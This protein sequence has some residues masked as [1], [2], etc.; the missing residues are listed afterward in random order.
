MGN[1]KSGII[2]I[3]VIE[4]FLIRNKDN[5]AMDIRLVLSRS[6]FD[7]LIVTNLKSLY[8]LTDE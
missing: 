5:K 7:S 4:F 8:G 3:A 2:F 6:R 1:E